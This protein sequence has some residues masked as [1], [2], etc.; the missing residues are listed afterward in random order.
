MG[1]GTPTPGA[2]L[3]V[4]G[5]LWAASASAHALEQLNATDGN[6][7]RLVARLTRSFSGGTGADGIGAKLNFFV[8]TESEGVTQAAAEIIAIAM[9]DARIRYFPVVR[10]HAAIVSKR[11]A[12][13]KRNCSRAVAHA[14]SSARE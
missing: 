3:D 8:E 12:R 1:I 13:F 14:A 11:T 5:N 7:A 6:T 10:F 9:S 4:A 2:T